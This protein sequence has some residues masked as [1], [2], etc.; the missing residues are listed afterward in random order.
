MSIVLNDDLRNGFVGVLLAGGQGT[1]FRAS[2][3]VA[4]ADKLLATLPDGRVVAV[5]AARLL[6]Q[7]LPVVIAV[8]RPGSDVLKNA[9][10]QEGCVVFL[11]PQTQRGMGASLAAAAQHTMAHVGRAQPR[12][13]AP[14]GCLVA[15]GDMPWL[16]LASVE[17]VLRAGLEHRVTA[18][19]FK[20]RRGHP[21][22]FA[23][24][25]MPELAAL[26]GDTGARAL[27]AR[28]GVH[29]VPCDDPGVLCDVDTT[30]DLV[31]G[32][33]LPD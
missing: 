25:L 18:P 19:T 13:H 26:D 6:R 15:L 16:S 27:L 28:H 3:G 10:E 5:A 8:V 7:V 22:A 14:R 17:A 24:E 33:R 1:R 12:V 9:L 32:G 30:A 31:A 4:Q 11:S 2:S 29:E 21:V 23:W 20:G